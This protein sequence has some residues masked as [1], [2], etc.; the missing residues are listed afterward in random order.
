MTRH[1]IYRIVVDDH[2]YVGRSKNFRF[3]S[4]V[5]LRMHDLKY[6]DFMKLI[7]LKI[8]IGLRDI[9]CIYWTVI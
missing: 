6:W 9:G 8:S 5:V 1:C 3:G 7:I 4:V 2:I